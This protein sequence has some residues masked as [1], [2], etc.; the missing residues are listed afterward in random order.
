M[1]VFDG[2]AGG[3]H[4]PAAAPFISTNAA[5]DAMNHP[6]YRSIHIP[7]AKAPACVTYLGG[8][9]PQVCLRSL[10][11]AL[12][13]SWQR[14][15]QLCL[16]VADLHGWH[17]MPERDAQG[18]PTRLLGARQ[19]PRFLSAL[20]PHVAKMYPAGGNRLAVIA[21]PLSARYLDVAAAKASLTP[22][23][24]AFDAGRA[25]APPVPPK[26]LAAPLLSGRKKG[27]VAITR[28]VESEVLGLAAQGASCGSIARHLCISKAA[29]S[30]LMRGKYKFAADQAPRP[31]LADDVPML[32]ARTGRKA[33]VTGDT[34][35]QVLTLHGQGYAQA[36]VARRLGVSRATVN[37][38]VHGKYKF[39]EGAHA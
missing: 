36:E 22:V 13:L 7:G 38:L 17:L 28:E 31:R 8:R 39:A 29:A 10:L 11:S 24:G 34:G 4:G 30:L 14:W 23:N 2:F 6:D 15:Q 35:R 33:T 12:G 37:L 1:P 32:H 18:R 9:H 20:A 27:G 3:T 19:V 16:Q 26:S 25:S 21:A 5:A